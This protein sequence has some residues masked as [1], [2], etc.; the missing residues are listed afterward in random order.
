MATKPVM[1]VIMDGW[2][3]REMTHGNAVKQAHTPNYDRYCQTLERALVNASGEAV[4]LVPDQMGNSE[5]GHMNLG[6]GRVVYQDITR[7]DVAIKTG[8]LAEHAVLNNALDAARARG[9]KAHLIGLVSPGGV[10]SHTRHLYALLRIAKRA[11][12]AAAVH[13]I[14]DGRDTPPESGAGYV[15]ALE[16]VI[17]KEGHGVIAT[18]SG[19]YYAMD[20]D[21]RWERTLL[22][23]NT[24]AYREGQRAESAAAAIQASYAA[25]VTDEFIMPTVIGDSDALGIAPG[26]VIICYNFR[27]DRMRQIVR[28]FAFQTVEGA[29]HRFVPDV[30][31]V[32]FTNYDNELPVSV[33]FGKDELNNT[34]AEWLS[35]H[36]KAQYHSAET[37]KYPHV[38]FFFNGRREEAFPGED[39]RIVPSPKVATY[40]LKPEMSAYELLDATLE[41]LKT[42]DD[43]FILVN[44]ANPDMVGHTGSLEAAIKAVEAVDECVG[45]LVDAVTTKGG[46]VIL[47]ADH[48]NCERMI[49]ELTGDPH[50]YHTT[51]LVPLFVIGSQY[52]KLRPYGILADVAPTVLDLLGMPLPEDMT[53]GTLIEAARN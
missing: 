45:R 36:G 49:E 44:F 25:G 26:D 1:L 31:V 27:A 23:F 15:Q 38:T 46:A 13:V 19:R 18:V 47:T 14:T 41:R 28:L 34:L 3:V 12:V 24:M 4:G 9:G 10:H 48:G 2:G 11:G 22:A 39:R 6:A 30:S 16:D 40:D 32:T 17:A 21:N 52:Y 5:V 43:D 29:G 20:R 8:E 50:T 35:K 42:H 7:I 33:V 51:N 37:E 53:G